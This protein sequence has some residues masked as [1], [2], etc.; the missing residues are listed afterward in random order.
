MEGDERRD[1]N[2]H[3]TQSQ[4]ESPVGKSI[5]SSNILDRRSDSRAKVQTGA[6]SRDCHRPAEGPVRVSDVEGGVEVVEADRPAC[7]DDVTEV[8]VYGP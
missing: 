1:T 4:G 6:V 5:S 8:Q 7:K 3:R 2:V